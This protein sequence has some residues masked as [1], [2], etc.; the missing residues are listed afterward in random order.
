MA[1]PPTR[2]AF[3]SLHDDR[4][5]DHQ[6]SGGE[7]RIPARRGSV[8][9]RARAFT[10][11]R[12]A[13]AG[14]AALSHGRLASCRGGRRNRLRGTLYGW[15]PG[16]VIHA[17]G[18]GRPRLGGARARSGH[19]RCRSAPGRQAHRRST[20]HGPDADLAAGA[21][22]LGGRLALP[23]L[24]GSLIAGAKEQRAWQGPAGGLEAPVPAAR[25]GSAVTVRRHHIPSP[26][27]LS[28]LWPLDC[29]GSM[30]WR[31]RPRGG[32]E[33]T[34][35]EVAVDWAAVPD[36]ATS[37]RPLASPACRLS[38]GRSARPRGART[39]PRSP[40]SR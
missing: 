4:R 17:V 13:C 5:R 29:W 39:A 36:G 30:A 8:V 20:A 12:A 15:S 24:L 7:L 37:M 3:I 23:P 10:L 11:R 19:P 14:V 35:A 31:R 1:W 26:P 22:R 38:A 21:D 25:A 6:R 40:H 33:A 16:G 32:S 28:R 34:V 27:S 18:G 2:M 9:I